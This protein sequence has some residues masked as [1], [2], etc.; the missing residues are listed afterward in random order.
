MIWLYILIALL[1]IVTYLLIV[2]IQLVVNTETK[3]Y[4]LN[5]PGIIKVSLD[6]PDQHFTKLRIRILFISFNLN[7][8]GNKRAQKKVTEKKSRTGKSINIKR[9]VNLFGS[10][11]Q[12][13][14]IKKLRADFDTGD[15][16]L[17][18]NLYPI[19]Q[20]INGNNI[21]I[22]VNFENRN[23]FDIYIITQIYK[24]I[25]SLFK[26]QQKK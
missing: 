11:V 10:I 6:N 25:F 20:S 15:F 19:T 24:L 26:Y 22:N 18:A 23:Q 21:D 12:N 4:F 8:L 16:P 17:N 1:T 13:F 2:P 3:R 7:P 14:K 9:L 5:Y